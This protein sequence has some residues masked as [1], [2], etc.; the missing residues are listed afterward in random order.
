M[1]LV[2]LL[3]GAVLLIVA[4]NAACTNVTGLSY[5]TLDA[6]TH[7]LGLGSFN[8][9]FNNGN[10]VISTNQVIRL[11]FNASSC[12]QD[13][14]WFTGS[15]SLYVSVT[16]NDD[17][18]T[19]YQFDTAG[20][21]QIQQ[22]DVV[23]FTLKALH[24]SV[25]IAAIDYCDGSGVVHGAKKRSV[26]TVNEDSSG[27]ATTSPPS[28]GIVEDAT[29]HLVADIPV[30]PVAYC[31]SHLATTNGHQTCVGVF[32]YLND[33]LYTVTLN[34][35][36]VFFVQSD[37]I[38]NIAPTSFYAGGTE[39]SIGVI[40][41]CDE[42][43]HPSVKVVIDTPMVNTSIQAVE[44]HVAELYRNYRSECDSDLVAWFTE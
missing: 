19:N 27:N 5:S 36:Y 6:R 2:R 13:I 4:A 37:G 26:R 1:V 12:L 35:T 8:A 21:S 7:A 28:S 15:G 34:S 33:N 44:R 24:A 9:Q 39:A 14:T 11:V 43:T 10:M 20:D 18:I 25:S 3:I 17:V 32:S 16:D 22:C 41:I 31:N 29:A 23:T 40:W 30:I 38:T 42:H